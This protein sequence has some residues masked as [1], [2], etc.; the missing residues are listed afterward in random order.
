[1]LAVNFIESTDERLLPLLLLLR[2]FTE[3]R[4]CSVACFSRRCAFCHSLLTLRQNPIS[5]SAKIDFRYLFL[6][7]GIISLIICALMAEKAV[8]DCGCCAVILEVRKFDFSEIGIR[9]LENSR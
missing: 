4:Q 1:L 9:M 8:V 5:I 6:A 2:E 7:T 3:L